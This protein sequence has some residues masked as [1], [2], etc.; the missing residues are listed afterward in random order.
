MVFVQAV[1]LRVALPRLGSRKA[2]L[3][4]FSFCTL[5]FLGYAFVTQ[6]W[7]IYPFL[8]LGA[9]QGFISPA[10]QGIMSTQISDSE[11]GELQGGLGSMASLT[12]IVSPP[13]MTTLF[14]AFTGAGAPIYFPGA[15]WLAAALL[16]LLSMAFFMRATSALDPAAGKA[17]SHGG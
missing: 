3:L 16:T 9:L 12:A 8:V 10:M 4:G 7:M 5:S 15:P 6:G 11:Q 2:A 14:A 13:F 17:G 1:L